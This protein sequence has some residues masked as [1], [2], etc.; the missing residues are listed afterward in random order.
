MLIGKNKKISPPNFKRE[1]QDD[2]GLW[3]VEVDVYYDQKQI[4]AEAKD[5]SKKKA[6][7]KASRE[8]LF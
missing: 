7:E 8:L 4:K 3:P 5:S 2:L 1:K 6:E